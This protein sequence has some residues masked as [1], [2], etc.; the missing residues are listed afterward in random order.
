MKKVLILHLLFC[1]IY[2]FSFA[3]VAKPKRF[4]PSA[5][6]SELW[7]LRRYELTGGLGFTQFFGDIGGFSIGENALGFRDITLKHTRYNFSTG[8]KYRINRDFTARISL[9][10]GSFH[11]TDKRG[12]NEIRGFESSTIFFEP[13]LMGE[14]Y[15]VKSKGESSYIFQR[16]SRI[17]MLPLLS[18]LNVYGF[19]GIGGLA[20]NV[21]FKNMPSPTG[22][23]KPG[24]FTAIIPAGIGV[25]M[26]YSARMN[27]GVELA[28]RFSFSDYLDGYTSV[29]SKANDV[30][31]F[32]LFNISYKLPSGFGGLPSFRFK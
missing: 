12:S 11:S 30:Y 4:S 26:S 2:S 20:Y 29:Y 28:R 24:G 21:N 13:C 6:D 19:T 18:T 15:F 16:G 27:I 8:M 22:L 9:S 25:S 17:V 5:S 1:F 3:Q 31:Y 32:V 10:V 7:K 23:T 14:Y